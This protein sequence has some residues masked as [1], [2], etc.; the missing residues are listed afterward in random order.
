MK[1]SKPKRKLSF[2]LKKLDKIPIP[3]SSKEPLIESFLTDGMCDMGAMICFGVGFM[4]LG[5][6]FA[7]L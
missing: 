4:M 1:K 7:H 6:F 2:E 3:K 5:F